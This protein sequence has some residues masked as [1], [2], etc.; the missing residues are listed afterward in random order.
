MNHTTPY[1]ALMKDV[2]FA[3]PHEDSNPSCLT[4]TVQGSDG[5]IVETLEAFHNPEHV[6]NYP[7]FQVGFTHVYELWLNA[8]AGVL[9]LS[10]QVSKVAHKMDVKIFAESEKVLVLSIEKYS[11]ADAVAIASDSE[12]IVLKSD[13]R[14]E[15]LLSIPI[16]VIL[17]KGK[18]ESYTLDPNESL[19]SQKIKRSV[20]RQLELD[21]DE[22][23]ESRE[24]QQ[25]PIRYNVTRK[26]PVGNYVSQYI[27]TESP[28]PEFPKE[29]NVYNVTRYDEYE[30]ISYIAY[31]QHD[32][33][34]KNERPEDIPQKDSEE[35]DNVRPINSQ[36]HSP[37]RLSFTQQHNLVTKPDG[38]VEI[39][40]VKTYESH[41]AHLYDQKMLVLVSSLLT[42]K[43]I[44]SE[45]IPEPVGQLEFQ[46][47]PDLEE[48]IDE[49]E[50]RAVCHHP[51]P[52]ESIRIVKKLLEEISDFVIRDEIK[53]PKQQNV[54]EKLVLLQ[55]AAGL[56]TKDHLNVI[57]DSLKHYD[58][59]IA[60]SEREKIKR[61]IWLNIL[62]LI[63]S[64]ESVAFIVQLIKDNANPPNKIICLWEAKEILEAL[65]E[66]IHEPDEEIFIQLKELLEI[67]HS[68]RDPAFHFFH[69]AVH[70]AVSRVIN[71]LNINLA[72]PEDEDS[73][74]GDVLRR[75]GL[76]GDGLRGDGLRGDGLRGDGLRGDR[77]RGDGLRGDGLRGDGLRGDGLRF[78]LRAAQPRKQKQSSNSLEEEIQ[79]FIKNTGAKLLNTDNKA[80]RVIYI[81]A[82][83]RS[84]LVEALPYIAPFVRGRVPI[85]SPKYINFIK[86]VALYALHNIVDQHPKE[87]LDLVVPVF[88]NETENHKIRTA[89]FGVLLRTKPSLSLLT[90]IADQSWKEESEE[91]GSF[92]TSV[93]ESH[94]NSSLPRDQE[95]A[96]RIKKILP[97]VKKFDRGQQHAK[98]VLRS[99]YDKL[100]ELGVVNELEITPSNESFI[101]ASLY[102][103]LGYNLNSLSEVISEV[104]L[105]IE[106]LNSRN[107]FDSILRLLKLKPAE[108]IPKSVEED[109]F[110]D[111]NIRT[112]PFFC[113][114]CI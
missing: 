106:G 42:L 68:E 73:L 55:K 53:E 98:K 37:I 62:P 90:L 39:D 79:E 35:D 11:F 45:N 36:L 69:S 50:I 1:F 78:F 77:L 41:L 19:L 43:Q 46:G 113:F 87:V 85:G 49:D 54:G 107:A 2:E 4:C 9:G 86:S 64:K 31:L 110:S 72:E 104:A 33:F 105:N 22:L 81:E 65:P 89:A 99:Y 29:R 3:R 52:S 58:D 91:V 25:G 63:G 38:I 97:L 6:I 7:S 10:P 17:G 48:E 71:R 16:K 32:N 61:Q 92:V 84:G 13:R 67:E 28:F 24:E 80:K 27:I 109:I 44:I 111:V 96:E 12:P 108:E 100:S 103:V 14:L 102:S 40:S 76:R 60:A 59:L 26:S 34:N 66:N 70:L 88:F 56:L 93:L 95:I 82:L 114:Q 112:S 20:L 83:V 23:P 47:L 18:V 15:H 30:N 74:R 57:Q 101:P 21:L 75:D 51:N 8:T 94:G 5:S